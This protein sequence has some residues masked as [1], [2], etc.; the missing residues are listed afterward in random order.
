M[1]F[2]VIALLRCDADGDFI[3]SDARVVC[4]KVTRGTG[5]EVVRQSHHGLDGTRTKIMPAG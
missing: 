1:L 2:L 3:E 4:P 5:A